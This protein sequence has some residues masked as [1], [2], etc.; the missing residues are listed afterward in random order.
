[1]F[2]ASVGMEKVKCNTEGLSE[3]QRETL[4]KMTKESQKLQVGGYTLGGEKVWEHPLKM[5]PYPLQIKITPITTV[6]GFSEDAV[7]LIKR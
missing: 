7:T 3:S 4:T 6:H 5:N 1:M 2:G